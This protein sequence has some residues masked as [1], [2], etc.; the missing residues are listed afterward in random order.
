MADEPQIIIFFIQKYKKICRCICMQHLYKIYTFSQKLRKETR[1]VKQTQSV[2]TAYPWPKPS[3][4]INPNQFTKCIQT[5]S[6]TQLNRQ[7]SFSTILK[8][9]ISQ[10]R[11][12]ITIPASHLRSASQPRYRPEYHPLTVTHAYGKPRGALATRPEHTSIA[13]YEDPKYADG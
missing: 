2:P 3:P 12:P 5:S 4:I 1:S 13:T 8:H 11:G 7:L 10:Q 9:H 6:N